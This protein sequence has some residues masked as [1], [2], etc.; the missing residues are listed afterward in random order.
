[1]SSGRPA[2]PH[3]TTVTRFR[4]GPQERPGAL[5]AGG[6]P[7]H[8]GPVLAGQQHGI[9]RLALVSGDRH[10]GASPVGGDQPCD[11]FR[12]HQRL[13]GQ[14]DHRGADVRGE[15]PQSGPERGSHA[16]APLRVVHGMDPVFR[17]EFELGGTGDDENRVRPAGRSIM[18]PRSARV[19]PSSMTSAF[20]WPKREPSPAASSTPATEVL[21]VAKRTRTP[22]AAA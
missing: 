2:S 20:G 16:G 8:L 6:H 12:A 11:R 5:V 14:G 9:T 22:P 4:A 13:V 19:C 15:G 1:M 10:R 7:D 18:I 3:S 17:R 21:T